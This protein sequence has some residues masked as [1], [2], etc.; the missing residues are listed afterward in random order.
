[1]SQN[2]PQA[3]L[4]LRFASVHVHCPFGHTDQASPFVFY[5]EGGVRYGL[6]K[7]ANLQLLLESTKTSYTS[8]PAFYPAGTGGGVK[9]AGE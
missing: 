9:A 8:H 4:V 5:P 2:E 7:V 3:T 1:M 6:R